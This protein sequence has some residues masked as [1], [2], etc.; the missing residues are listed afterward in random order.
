MLG[1]AL[2]C[3]T[4]NDDDWV[5]FHLKSLAICL[6]ICEALQN[7]RLF[8][9][10][11]TFFRER[12]ILRKVCSMLSKVPDDFWKLIILNFCKPLALLLLFKAMIVRS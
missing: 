11:Q 9:A 5:K 6:Q 10:S 2:A 8:E 1:F 3:L 4:N 7:M 12:Y